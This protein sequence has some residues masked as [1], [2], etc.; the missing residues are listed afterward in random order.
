MKGRIVHLGKH[1]SSSNVSA[2]QHGD[3]CHDLDVIRAI[4]LMS[5]VLCCFCYSNKIPKSGTIVLTVHKWPT[6]A[7]LILFMI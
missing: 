4:S 6:K 5:V 7:S 1:I 3:T 2:H